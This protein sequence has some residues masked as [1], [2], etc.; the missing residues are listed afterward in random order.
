MRSITLSR[1]SRALDTGASGLSF[2]VQ[3][4]GRSLLTLDEV[5]TLRADCQLLFLAGQCPIVAAKRRY[6]TD[7][8]FAGRFDPA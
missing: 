5:R 3:H 7:R 2:G 8:E 6:F 1:L 4:V